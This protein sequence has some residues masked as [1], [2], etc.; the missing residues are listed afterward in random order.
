MAN[1]ADAMITAAELADLLGIS[2]ARVTQL[3]AAGVLARADRKLFRAGAAV[4]AYIENL[5]GDARRTTQSVAETRVREARAREIEIRTAEREHRLVDTEETLHFID[6]MFGK[7]VVALSGVP[8]RVG[9]NDLELR[10][11]VEVEIDAARNVAA[12]EFG[13]QAAH[14]R[15]HGEAAL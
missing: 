7:F 4:R 11:R 10:R 15:E 14:L 1:I 5:R 2:R 13:R 6:I 8:A 3:V 9:R 12:D